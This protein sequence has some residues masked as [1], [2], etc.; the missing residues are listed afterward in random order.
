MS[1]ETPVGQLLNEIFE[2]GRTPEEVCAD[3]PE[4]LLEVR[5]RRQRI[6]LLKAEISALFPALNSNRDADTP[7][8]LTPAAELPVPK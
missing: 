4:L 5:K 6:R 3:C 2:S 8:P 7:A 1:D